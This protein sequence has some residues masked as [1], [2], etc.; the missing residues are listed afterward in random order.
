[1]VDKL[2]KGGLLAW[3]SL[4]ACAVIISTEAESGLDAE[5]HTSVV[6]SYSTLPGVVKNSFE[7]IC[8]VRLV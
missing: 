1:M 7:I 8:G 5:N 3:L 2:K 4:H 6:R